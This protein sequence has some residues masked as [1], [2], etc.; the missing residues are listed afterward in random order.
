MDHGS[1][2]SSKEPVRAPLFE[3]LFVMAIMAMLLAPLILTFVLPESED[4][5]SSEKRELAP[6]PQL[7]VNDAVNPR[8]LSEAGD[9]Y[10]DHFAMRAQLVELDTTIKQSVFGTSAV[11]SVV[12]GNGGWLY[13]AGELGDYQQTNVMSDQALQNAAR[14][15]ALAQEVLESNG[16][17]FLVVVAPNKSSLYPT[18]MPFYYV[19]GEGENNYTRLMSLLRQQGVH[20]VDLKTLFSTREG[21]WYLKRDSHWTDEGALLAYEA[22]CRALNRRA[23]SY[24]DEEATNVARVGDLDAMLHPVSAEP[25]KQTHRSAVDQ[26]S[27]ANDA[28]SVED[29]YIVTNAHGKAA[30]GN[31][32]MY[33][34]S[35]G[36]A[37]LPPF[38]SA[39][40]QA[41]FTKLVPYDMS[42]RMCGFADDIVIE[43]AERHLAYFASNPPYMPAPVRVI[44]NE[45]SPTKSST[46]AFFSTNGPYLVVEGSLDESVATGAGHVFVEV[47]IPHVGTRTYEAFRVSKADG[48]GVDFEGQEYES[49]PNIVGDLGYRVYVALRQDANEVPKG[50]SARILVGNEAD[51]VEVG[52][53]TYAGE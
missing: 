15:L 26:Y 19:P 43:R 16:K 21:S 9:Y 13:Y 18:N 30:R 33:R 45:N 31:L 22:I 1:R 24:S 17:R 38:A 40:K 28:T 44:K 11:P 2:E 4:A 7:M 39:Y 50:C 6:V 10:A 51:C 25:E 41:V 27:F 47:S 23:S 5:S 53:V 8:V 35:F 29:S 32:L 12:V 46:T 34:D 3:R 37:L 20:V 48:A 49:S 42:A 52:S 14:N 36:N